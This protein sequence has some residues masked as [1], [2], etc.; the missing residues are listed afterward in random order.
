MKREAPDSYTWVVRE[1]REEAPQVKSFMIEAVGE[2]PPFTS[3]QYLT[4]R[5][6]GFEPPEGKSYSISSS[7]KDALLRLTVK[8]LGSFSKVLSEHRVGDTL[9]TSAPYG[10]FYP[11][12]DVARHLVF[13]AGGIGITPV[14]SIIETLTKNGYTQNMTLFYSNRTREDITF[15]EALES[16]E[17]V[18]PSLQIFHH[19][20]REPVRDER[21]RE[22]RLTG[23]SVLNS[24][25]KD[26][27]TTSDYFICGSIDFTK[28]LWRELRDAGIPAT[29]LYTEGFY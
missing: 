3:G 12:Q 24:L 1:V 10:F 7:D 23:K 15:R 20:T 4:V 8:E 14:M 9:T 5:L 13:I 11:E 19:I 28:S 17:S 2:C 18:T 29:Q 27:Q 26:T 25:P 6:P 16:L 22:G 21:H